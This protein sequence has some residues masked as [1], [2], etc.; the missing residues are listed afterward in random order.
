MIDH[1][2]VL[3]LIGPDGR[4][5][6]PLPPDESGREIAERLGRYLS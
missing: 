5:L 2:A 4:Y 6:A 3:L 1:T